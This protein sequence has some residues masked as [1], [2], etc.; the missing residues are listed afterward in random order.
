M[1]RGGVNGWGGTLRPPLH[2]DRGVGVLFVGRALSTRQAVEERS[3]GL[4]SRVRIEGET[5]LNPGGQLGRYVWREGPEVPRLLREHLADELRKRRGFERRRSGEAVKERDADR[6]DVGAMVD[7]RLVLH[8]LRR[9]VHRRPEDRPARGQPIE[10]RIV[11]VL[12][13][14]EVEELRRDDTIGASREEDVRWLDVA[15]NDARS[16]RGLERGE[17]R[18]GHLE[19]PLHGEP[20]LPLQ[21][22]VEVLPLEELHDHEGLLLVDACV[23]DLRDGGVVDLGR[24]HRLPKEALDEV[25]AHPEALDHHLEGHLLSQD[26]VGRH[27]DPP[28]SALPE[29][30]FDAVFVRDQVPRRERHETR[31]AHALSSRRARRPRQPR[32]GHGSC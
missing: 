27:V 30:P 6:I 4:R 7:L 23:E 31:V 13:D 11:D 26:A 32:F 25:G 10:E 19:R 14:A 24:G 17:D 28:H 29:Q 9:D 20:A 5:A 15:V 21:P 8:L 12:R 22:L 2:G 18:P 16:V 3:S 1:P